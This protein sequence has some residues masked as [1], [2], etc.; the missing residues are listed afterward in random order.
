MSRAI[1]R[2]REA[3]REKAVPT[4]EEEEWNAALEWVAGM[5]DT[6]KDW[7]GAGA[8]A[9][10][11]RA[12]RKR[13][14]WDVDVDYM[15]G[16]LC[17]AT[18][19][20]EAHNADEAAEKAVAVVLE[21]RESTSVRNAVARLATHPAPASE[22]EAVANAV[23]EAE[24]KWRDR[25]AAEADQSVRVLGE[26]L[27]HLLVDDQWNNVEPLL[28]AVAAGLAATHPAPATVT[29]TMVDA[30]YKTLAVTHA[31]QMNQRERVRLALTAALGGA[32]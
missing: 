9:M 22:G 4:S 14:R 18:V 3:L 10:T 2:I 15:A 13:I 17:T 1:E 26:R 27:S 7:A 19:S 25:L 20:V 30:A 21:T 8:F 16:G 12:G 11:V 32:R 28:L 31:A 29:E 6:E 24:T 23:M 5:L